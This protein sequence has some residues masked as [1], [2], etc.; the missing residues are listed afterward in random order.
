MNKSTHLVTDVV[1][2][3]LIISLFRTS[4][5][6]ELLGKCSQFKL[7]LYTPSLTGTHSGVNDEPLTAPYWG[8]G[9]G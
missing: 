4:Q 1:T 8:S 5:S 2:A 7:W 3:D 9:G 6:V